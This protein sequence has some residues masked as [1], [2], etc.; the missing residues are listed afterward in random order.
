[1]LPRALGQLKVVDDN[2][3]IETNQILEFWLVVEEDLL[4]NCVVLG[5]VLHRLIVAVGVL[6]MIQEV[7]KLPGIWEGRSPLCPL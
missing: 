3:S 4:E 5:D 2:L 1:M 6:L 7:K